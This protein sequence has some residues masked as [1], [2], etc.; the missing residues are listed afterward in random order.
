MR[1]A[2]CRRRPS[3]GRGSRRRACR[4]GRSR[5][6]AARRGAGRSPRARRPRR[7]APRKKHHALAADRA[8]ERLVGDLVGRAGDVPGIL[9][10]HRIAPSMYT[11]N[12]EAP[13][14]SASR[15]AQHSNKSG[16]CGDFTN[17]HATDD[18]RS[19]TITTAI[20]YND[21]NI[22]SL[23]THDSGKRLLMTRLRETS[24]RRSTAEASPSRSSAKSIVDLFVM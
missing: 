11:I 15:Q 12:R 22:T 19:S 13:R 8:A 2:S 10:E 16:F 5:A 9:R 17:S 24:A 6:T 23:E 7:P 14:H 20:V 1:D 3:P 21:K 18:I 4:R